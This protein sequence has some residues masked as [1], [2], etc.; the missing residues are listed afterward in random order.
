VKEESRVGQKGKRSWNP[1]KKPRDKE[2]QPDRGGEHIQ[3]TD[4]LETC[5]FDEG[6]PVG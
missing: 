4:M 3:G 2:S 5:W 1:F 6:G